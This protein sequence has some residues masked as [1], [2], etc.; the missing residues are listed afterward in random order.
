MIT[1]LDVEIEIKGAF[2]DQYKNGRQL[3]I[4]DIIVV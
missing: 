4:C 1:K 2:R 3:S